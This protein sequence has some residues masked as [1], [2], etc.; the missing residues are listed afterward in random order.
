M[1]IT[2]SSASLTHTHE[3]VEDNRVKHLE[4]CKYLLKQLKGGTYL[5]PWD[6]ILPSLKSHRKNNM[7]KKLE[8]SVEI[9]LEY[10]K[11]IYPRKPYLTKQIKINGKDYTSIRSWQFEQLGQLASKLNQNLTSE[12]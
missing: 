3:Q 2:L 11:Y 8:I 5:I 7:D 4:E 12:H 6:G 10:G 1:A 9:G